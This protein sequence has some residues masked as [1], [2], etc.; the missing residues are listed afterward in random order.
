MKQRVRNIKPKTPD[1]VDATWLI[2][3]A[4]QLQLAS[5]VMLGNVNKRQYSKVH[6]PYH[7]KQQDV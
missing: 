1:I 5:I 2:Y 4:C 6:M 3:N 7:S